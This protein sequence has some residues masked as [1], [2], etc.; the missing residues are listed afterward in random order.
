MIVAVNGRI[1]MQDE[2]DYTAKHQPVSS[3]KT[4]NK[5]LFV[6]TP[7][8]EPKQKQGASRRPFLV[9][10]KSSEIN[11]T[12]LSTDKKNKS[13]YNNRQRPKSAGVS[14]SIETY[15]NQRPSSGVDFDELLRKA[16]AKK[17]VELKEERRKK[18]EVM[19]FFYFTK[20]KIFILN[21]RIG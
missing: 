5:S 4:E 11:R 6:P 20:T 8:K 10:P 21:Y 14:K 15:I 18:E 19:K 17:R 13:D 2:D 1:E 12:K 9:R 3:M 16:A 7:P